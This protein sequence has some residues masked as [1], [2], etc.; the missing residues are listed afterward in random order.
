MSFAAAPAAAQK[1]SISTVQ[2]DE[3]PDAQPIWKSVLWVLFLVLLNYVLTDF[4]ALWYL[5]RDVIS[6]WQRGARNKVYNRYMSIWLVLSDVRG[7]VLISS[8]MKVFYSPNTPLTFSQMDFMRSKLFPLRRFVDPQTKKQGGLLTPDHLCNSVLLY[9]N[10]GDDAFD[11]WIQKAQPARTTGKRCAQFGCLSP[12]DFALTFES[13][14]VD[15]GLYDYTPNRLKGDYSNYYGVYPGQTVA[16]FEDWKG[17]LQAWANGGLEKQLNKTLRDQNKSVW[18][19]SFDTTQQL[20]VL[21]DTKQVNDLSL[22]QD[23][24]AQPDNVF[25]RSG[26]DFRSPLVV[27]FVNQKAYVEGVTYQFDAQAFLALLAP[28]GGS[29]AGGWVG[30]LN[31]FGSTSASDDLSRLCFYSIDLDTR[32]GDKPPCSTA[33]NIT[34]AAATTLGSG[35]VFTYMAWHQTKALGEAGFFGRRLGIVGFVI[36][37]CASM[38]GMKITKAAQACSAAG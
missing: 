14:K 28:Q 9:S 38:A 31:R 20:W 10:D 32:I 35:S 6:W 30:M 11:A 23:V 22:W 17:C 24:E 16:A 2:I 27:A 37:A 21:K 34:G 25:A 7:S 33:Q 3:A 5:N 8:L 12:G 26:I 4:F 13:T 29:V 18:M 36:A 15:G 1:L 19:W